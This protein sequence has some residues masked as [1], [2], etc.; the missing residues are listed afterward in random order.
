MTR[1]VRAAFDIETV[2][3][4]LDDDEQPDFRDSQHFELL[5]AAVA[6]EYPD[7]SRETAVHWRD[8]WGSTAELAVAEWIVD[9]LADVETVVTYNGTEF[10]MLHLVGRAR[11]AGAAA[12]RREPFERAEALVDRIDHVDLQP[13][14]WTA[15]GDYTSLEGTL[16]AVGIDP[17]ATDPTG[18]DHGVP[19]AAWP[20]TP[21]EPVESR[22]VARLGEIYLDAVDAGGTVA[23]GSGGDGDA[24][25]GDDTV[26]DSDTDGDTADGSDTPAVDADELRAMLDHYARA[27]VEYLFDLA[28]A[29]PFGG[30]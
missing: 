22:D 28:D 20:T 24:D 25:G 12:G 6:Y 18:F 11:I 21:D 26:S 1:P 13:P 14:A 17:T 23:G 3:P 9:S 29:R 16:R 5:A 4:Q 2:S 15:F 27:D 7:G 19:R 8:G 10:D 30:D